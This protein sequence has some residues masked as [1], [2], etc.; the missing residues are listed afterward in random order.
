[1]KVSFTPSK[2]KPS[3]ETFYGVVYAPIRPSDEEITNVVWVEKK[4]SEAYISQNTEDGEVFVGLITLT[5]N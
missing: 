2:L 5:D 4:P 1:M 3:G